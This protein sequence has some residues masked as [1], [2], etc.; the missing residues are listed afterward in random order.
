[1]RMILH[2]LVEGNSVRGTARLCDVEKRTV[3][4]LLKSA[5]DHCER[6]LENRLRGVRVNDLQ[7]DKTWAFVFKKEGHKWANEMDNQRI[8]DA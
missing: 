3:L 4:T 7:L 1:M 2:C 8:G 6:L 5:G